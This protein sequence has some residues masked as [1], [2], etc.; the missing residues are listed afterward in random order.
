MKP[1]FVSEMPIE[2]NESVGWVI[3]SE[4]ILIGEP[5]NLAHIGTIATT[6]SEE[7]DKTGV[8]RSKI[9]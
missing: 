6:W 3:K 1:G 7:I 4:I 9:N 5:G 8:N 2:I